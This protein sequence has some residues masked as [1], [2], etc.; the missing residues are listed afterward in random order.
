MFHPGP[1]SYYRMG[2]G[3]GILDE[4]SMARN[5]A[6]AILRNMLDFRKTTGIS[7]YN[8]IRLGEETWFIVTMNYGYA[9]IRELNET[10]VSRSVVIN[11]SV[12]S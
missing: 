5:E 8:R 7:G 9:G 12:I 2:G 11:M 6:L 4:I 3:L 10:L 1:V